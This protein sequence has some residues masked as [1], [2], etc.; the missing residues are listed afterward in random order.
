MI[1]FVLHMSVI[2][3][4]VRGRWRRVR[5]ANRILSRYCR[6]AL[7]T[8]SVRPRAVGLENIAGIQNGLFV[9]NHLSYVD[10]LVISSVKPSCFVT[11]VEIRDAPVLGTVCKRAGCLFVE[12]RTRKNLLNEVGELAEGL[13][14][15]V[16]AAIFPEATSSNGEQILRFRRPLYKAAIDAQVPVIP[17]CLNYHTIDGQPTN[18]VTRDWVF[19]YGEINFLPHLWSLAQSNGIDVDVVFLK[20]HSTEGHSDPTELAAITQKDVEAVFKPVPS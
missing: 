1:T 16:N 11:S 18:R 5:L 17:F 4:F 19:Y 20:P 14:N 10:V 2:W 15:G 13:K 6:F 8:L 12:R 3:P 7:W 9:G